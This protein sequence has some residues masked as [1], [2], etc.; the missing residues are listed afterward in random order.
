MATLTT[1][2]TDSAVEPQAKRAASTVKASTLRQT[3]VVNP[4]V[5]NLEI[6]YV[7]YS[8]VDDKPIGK[9]GVAKMFQHSPVAGVAASYLDNGRIDRL[10]I[11]TME[12]CI[13]VK[14]HN[15]GRRPDGSN[16]PALE[17]AEQ[18]RVAAWSTAL[19]SLILCRN[20]GVLLGFDL[21]PLAM[22]LYRAHG[23][24]LANGVDIQSF[25]ALE[26]PGDRDRRPLHAIQ[27]LLG[28][29]DMKIHTDNIAYAFRNA[30][31]RAGLTVQ[32]LVQRA[33]MA[34]FLYTYQNGA[35]TLDPVKRIDTNSMPNT[36]SYLF[37]MLVN[38]G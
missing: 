8:N 1:T 37:F 21:A 16:P 10:A 2:M 33:W 22:S 4:A 7:Q 19:Q 12:K 13:V 25:L 15:Q 14:F 27:T 23:I 26:D 24:R 30:T 6:Q 29:A 20:S 5:G 38:S 35:S 28:E 18:V 36:V 31:Q 17:P 34:Q 11:S 32:Q 3:L 9:T